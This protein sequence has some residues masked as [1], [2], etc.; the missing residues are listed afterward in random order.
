MPERKLLSKQMTMS[1][2]T[3]L[4]EVNPFKQPEERKASVRVAKKYDEARMSYQEDECMICLFNKVEVAL[5]KCGHSFCKE[6]VSQMQK[7]EQKSCPLCACSG[8]SKVDQRDHI[9]E[10]VDVQGHDNVLK[11]MGEKLENRVNDAIGYVLQLPDTNN[12]DKP[13]LVPLNYDFLSAIPKEQLQ[14]QKKT[15]E[16]AMKRI[17][18]HGVIPSEAG[19]NPH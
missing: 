1:V 10:I 4:G 8:F 16:Y 17:K 7:R 11:D 9:F 12:D 18:N 13:G 3:K 2:D 19:F 6:C 15:R 5:P 14:R